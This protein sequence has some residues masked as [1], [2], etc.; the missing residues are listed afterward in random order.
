MLTFMDGLV[1]QFGYSKVRDFMEIQL[2]H[3][4]DLVIKFLD[5]FDQKYGYLKPVQQQLQLP[6]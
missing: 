5:K 3:E 2:I 1:D 6:D 4:N